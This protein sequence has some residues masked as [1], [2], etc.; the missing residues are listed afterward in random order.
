MARITN[1]PSQ[2]AVKTVSPWSCEV[3]PLFSLVFPWEV[4]MMMLVAVV[5]VVVM[6]MVVAA[7]VLRPRLLLWAEWCFAISG[8]KSTPCTVT[9]SDAQGSPP[10]C[11]PRLRN[12][13]TPFYL[14][15][16]AHICPQSAIITLTSC[17]FG[18]LMHPAHLGFQPST[19]P[20]FLV[21]LCI[22][23]AINYNPLHP[24]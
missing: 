21:P 14:E 7:V 19:P 3:I 10:P 23:Q 9:Y 2:F 16:L 15:G 12:T 8:E 22:T 13:L 20:A 5:V 11:N 24:N 18:G 6:T 17:F 1:C 4:R